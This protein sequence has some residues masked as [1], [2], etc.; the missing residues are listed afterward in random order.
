[1]ELLLVVFYYLDTV[2]YLIKV[3]YN[4]FYLTEISY[5]NSFITCLQSKSYKYANNKEFVKIID[6]IIEQDK[7]QNAWAILFR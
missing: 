7:I 4:S 1:M 3:Q 5:I 2:A 6:D